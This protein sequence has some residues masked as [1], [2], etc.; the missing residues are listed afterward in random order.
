M[1][2]S[3]RGIIVV[4]GAT[5]LQ[6][7]AVAKHLLQ[8]GWHVRALTRRPNG[9]PAAALAA[10]GAEIVQGDMADLRALQPIFT[11]AYGVYS[12]QN[13]V[14]SGIEAEVAQ[15]KN[16]ADAAK[17]A[18][19]QHLV[20]GSAGI[21]R[22]GTGIPSWESKLEIEEHM[23]RVGLPLTVLRPMAFMELMTEKKFYPAMSTW[24]VMPKLMGEERKVAWLCASDLGAIAAKA[25][26]HPEQFIGSELKLAGDLQSIGDCRSIHREVTGTDPARFPIPVWAF[27]RLG[28][29]GRDLSTMWRWLRSASLDVD[30]DATRMLHPE[31]SGVREWLRRRK[32]PESL[33][34]T[35]S[36]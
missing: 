11:G 27:E 21:G 20:F 13:P 33:G 26:A 4:T 9:R 14:L 32:A 34:A 30:L 5:G 29:V 18:G 35:R 31:V 1:T 16:I 28:F 12:V 17:R 15:G 3:T 10:L 2:V 24:H 23:K 25:F 36:S 7:G 6:G 19:V 8:D 22:K